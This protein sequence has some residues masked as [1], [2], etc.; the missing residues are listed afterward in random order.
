MILTGPPDTAENTDRTPPAAPAGQPWWRTALWLGH[1]LLR[2]VL[3]FELLAYA[4]SK[5]LLVQMGHVDYTDGVRTVGEKSPMGLLWAFMGFS[6]VVQVL[7][8]LVELL[9]AVL[10]IWRRTAWVGG[11][12]GAV[13]MGVVTLLNIE[14][15]VPV[16]PLALAMTIGFLLVAA[17]EAPRVLRFLA[18]RPAGR[19]TVPRPVPWP[20]VHRFTGPALAVAGLLLTAAVGA[21]FWAFHPP[22]ARSDSS[23]PGV[24]RVVD[25]GDGGSWR[26]VAFG[27]W[28][29][30]DGLGRIAVRQSDGTLLDG[31][32]RITGQGTLEFGAEPVVP[33]GRPAG[34]AAEPRSVMTWTQRPDGTVEL[35]GEGQRLVVEPD[36]GARV[37]FDG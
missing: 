9:A 7:A 35:S 18:G 14:F 33:G 5:V 24:Y 12:V 29:D 22:N 6:P 32:Y 2:V 20:R 16:T 27:Q 4:W 25:A 15:V 37:L 30:R 3:L 21:S 36:R 10:L 19:S 8:G 1:G 23:L 31:T 17:P 28:L 26:Q 13:S 11:L 34:R